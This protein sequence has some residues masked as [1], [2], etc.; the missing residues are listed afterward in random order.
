MMLELIKQ[1]KTMWKPWRTRVTFVILMGFLCCHQIAAFAQEN[2]LVNAK[3]ERHT[4]VFKFQHQNAS[5]IMDTIQRVIDDNQ[6]RIAFD[7]NSNSL[8]ASGHQKTL[9]S[10]EELISV[11]DVEQKSKYWSKSV[12]TVML[13]FVWLV[14][15]EL[16]PGVNGHDVPYDLEATV[17]RLSGKF[18]LGRLRRASQVVINHKLGDDSNFE[19]SGTALIPGSREIRISGVCKKNQDHVEMKVHLVTGMVRILEN[20][21]PSQKFTKP[22]CE[23]ETTISVPIGRPVFLGMTSSDSK[24]S[25]FVVQVLDATEVMKD[26]KPTGVSN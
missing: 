14:D 23:I 25:L 11:L 10:V 17:E 16:M 1:E 6:L 12:D 15:E 19:G 7:E 9:E 13:R 18:S 20:D 4:K 24:A 3:P 26:P 2:P 8:I 5:S 22:D 21:K